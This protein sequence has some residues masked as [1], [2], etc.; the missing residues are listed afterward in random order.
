[1]TIS[2]LKHKL[3]KSDMPDQKARIILN[4]L[5]GIAELALEALQSEKQAGHIQDNGKSVGNRELSSKKD[6]SG[7]STR[8]ILT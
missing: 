4:I 5:Q 1:M 3:K 6:S 2:E 8:G 7:F